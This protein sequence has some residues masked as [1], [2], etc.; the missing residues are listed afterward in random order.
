MKNDQGRVRGIIML[1][2]DPKSMFHF[3]LSKIILK[4]L[5]LRKQEKIPFIINK[6]T[7]L[8]PRKRKIFQSLEARSE[9]IEKY[10]PLRLLTF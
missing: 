9:E 7:A 8:I 10:C 6:N 1:I 4:G 2:I 5:F 3:S